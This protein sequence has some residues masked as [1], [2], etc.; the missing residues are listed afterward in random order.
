MKCLIV[1]C[2]SDVVARGWC[3][4]HYLR[5]YKTGDP[6]GIRQKRILRGKEHPGFK[7]GLWDDPIYSIWLKMMDRCYNKKNKAYKNYGG[8]GIYVCDRWHDYKKF[9]E[10]MGSRPEKTSIDRINN[11]DGYSPENCRWA[12]STQQARN[13]RGIKLNYELAEKMRSEKRRCK[14]GRGEGLTRQQIAEKYGVSV[15]TVKKVLC[16]AYWSPS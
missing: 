7:H 12:T 16:G 15:A 11:D 2:Q 6:M 10:D 13:R 1:D 14:N 9:M 3:R 5:W 4:K 8:R